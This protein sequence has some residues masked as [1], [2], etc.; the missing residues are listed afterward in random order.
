MKEYVF[1]AKVKGYSPRISKITKTVM[2]EGKEEVLKK[3]YK[4]YD[5]HKLVNYGQNYIELQ[6]IKDVS[7]NNRGS[8]H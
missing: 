8:F 5:D 3:F 4:V 7:E 6:L 2:S 1:T